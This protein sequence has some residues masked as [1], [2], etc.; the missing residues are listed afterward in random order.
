MYVFWKA[1][2]VGVT[3]RERQSSSIHGLSLQI[4]TT[5]KAGL[6]S[7]RE[8]GWASTWMA[9]CC[10]SPPSQMHYQAVGSE[11][12]RLSLVL[13]VVYRTTASQAVAGLLHRGT[14]PLRQLCEYMLHGRYQSSHQTL[15][16]SLSKTDMEGQT[17]SAYGRA[18]T[19]SQSEHCSKK[20]RE[21]LCSISRATLLLCSFVCF[22]PLFTDT[23]VT[24]RV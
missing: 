15:M 12:A 14:D 9:L 18:E 19:V 24:P 23:V 7:I 5:A 6:D 16:G 22:L 2:C 20:F 3:K 17:A 10:F 13:L 8:L 4:A 1:L 11:A 21:T